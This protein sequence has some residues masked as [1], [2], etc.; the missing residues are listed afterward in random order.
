[1]SADDFC[2][3]LGLPPAS[4]HLQDEPPL[5]SQAPADFPAERVLLLTL[6]GHN[7]EASAGVLSAVGP[8]HFYLPDHRRIFEAAAALLRQGVTPDPE[9]VGAELER[10]GH[11][12]AREALRAIEAGSYRTT[13]NNISHYAKKLLET[14]KLRRVIDVGKKLVQAGFN[15]TEPADVVVARAQERLAELEQ[16]GVAGGAPI[17]CL[18]LDDLEAAGVPGP[19]WILKGWLAQDDVASLGGWAA[20]GKS[21]LAANIAVGVAAGIECCGLQPVKA[22]PVLFVG[23]EQGREE[24]ARL[25]FRIK[26]GFGLAKFPEGL[27]VASGQGI[28]LSTRDGLLRLE[29]WIRQHGPR[30]LIFDSV[31]QCFGGAQ[32][33]DAVET[34][35]VYRNLFYLR[36]TYGLAIL[37]IHHMGKPSRDGRVDL[38]HLFRGS[39]AHTTQPSTAWAYMRAGSAGELTQV[40]RRGGDATSLL[41]EYSADRNDAGEIVAIRLASKGPVVRKAT[42]QAQAEM[43]FKELAVG[44][45]SGE[46]TT[47]QAL[48][49]GDDKGWSKNT[50]DLAL[51]QLVESGVFCKPGRGRYRLAPGVR[52]DSDLPF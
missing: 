36:D 12:A 9:T 47:S 44:K 34:G 23:Q 43:L 1:M 22:L 27:H 38:L 5:D 35:A 52:D 14:A 4:P 7:R 30:L 15:E 26:Q 42:S 8:S 31:Q 33:N 20:C 48:A 40:K 32:E 2:A 45:V 11:G 51:K 24:D 28:D 41:I 6:V 25:F 17:E 13:P 3:V 10:R 18:P 19:D 21:T 39:S 16:A 37:L 46:I 49:A 50:C 29:R